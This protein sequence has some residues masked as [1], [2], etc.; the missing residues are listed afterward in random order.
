MEV[1]REEFD[2]IVGQILSERPPSRGDD[3]LGMQIDFDLHLGGSDVFD[4]VDVIQASDP[5]NLLVARC[6]PASSDATPQELEAELKRIWT[7]DIRYRFYEAHTLDHAA[8]KV[9]LHGVTVVSEDGFFVTASISV[10]LGPA[11]ALG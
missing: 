8:D 1:S 4:D 10:D 9:R 5:K 6:K 7:Q 3:L 2:K 11:G